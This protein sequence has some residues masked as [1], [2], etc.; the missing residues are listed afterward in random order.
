MGDHDG[1][2]PVDSHKGPGERAR[3]DGGVDEAWVSVVA[4]VE[5]AEVDEVQDEENLSPGKVG[6]SKEHD[7]GEVEEV[8]HDEVASTAG[9][10]V[11][12]VGVA[13]EEVTDITTLKDE[14]NNPKHVSK[15][16]VWDC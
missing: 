13:R 1:T 8:V 12:D 11:A 4:E 10:S 9:S 15:G 6:S 14:E 3:H 5:R 16:T 7:K 2:I